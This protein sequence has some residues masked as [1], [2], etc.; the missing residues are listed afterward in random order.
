MAKLIAMFMILIAIQFCLILYMDQPANN[1]Q[2]WKFVTGVNNWGTTDLIVLFSTLAG[3]LL[4][5]GIASG[6]TFRFVIDFTVV[7]QAIAMLFGFG[8]VF[9][10]LE[11]VVRKEFVSR[12]FPGCP[13]NTCTPAILLSA[14]IIG[15]FALYYLWSVIEWWRGKDV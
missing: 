15:P 9:M 12:F 5:A 1:T 3:G 2:L 4:L 11:S 13:I 6:G 14:I 10:N 8:V 7:S